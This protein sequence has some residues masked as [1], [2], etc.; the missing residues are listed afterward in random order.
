MLTSTPIPEPTANPAPDGRLAPIQMQDS[1]ALLS[2][3]SETELT[4]IGDDPEQLTRALTGAGPSYREE[5]AEFSDAS[6]TRPSPGYSWQG[7][8]PG[9]GR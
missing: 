9:R 1:G 6:K 5:Q 2:A 4:C 8:Y 7:S 3:L